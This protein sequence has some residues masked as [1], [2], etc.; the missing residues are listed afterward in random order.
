MSDENFIV[1]IDN[2]LVE[3]AR[4]HIRDNNNGSLMTPVWDTM[5][6]GRLQSNQNFTSSSTPF[7]N[8]NTIV[9]PNQ[10]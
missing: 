4:Q 3:N 10:G 1:T 9:R 2:Y 5:N 8:S 6:S 7:E